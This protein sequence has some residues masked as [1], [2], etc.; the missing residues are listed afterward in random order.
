MRDIIIF[1]HAELKKDIILI[2]R[3]CMS[4][5]ITFGRTGLNPHILSVHFI[6]ARRYLQSVGLCK[7]AYFIQNVN[8]TYNIVL[9]GK[10]FHLYTL[11]ILYHSPVRVTQYSDCIV[12]PFGKRER[13]YYQPCRATQYR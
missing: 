2:R 3:W 9:H 6:V 12:V 5:F 11:Y 4:T 10:S 13:Y 7:F 1:Y 8:N